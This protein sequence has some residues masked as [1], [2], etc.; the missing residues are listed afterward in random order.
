MN[1][2][3]PKEFKFINFYTLASDMLETV[4]DLN[5][6]IELAEI[7]LEI[8]RSKATEECI[9]LFEKKRAWTLWRKAQIHLLT[10]K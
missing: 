9:L 6:F 1:Y 5:A 10:L 3:S 4:D 2:Y 8:D 7:V